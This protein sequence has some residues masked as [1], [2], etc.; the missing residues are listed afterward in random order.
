MACTR[1]RRACAFHRKPAAL[2]NGLAPLEV[3]VQAVE[4]TGTAVLVD[5]SGEDL[6]RHMRVRHVGHVVRVAQMLAD[7]CLTARQKPSG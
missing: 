3:V 6:N 1:R 2:T 5:A 7:A 4:K